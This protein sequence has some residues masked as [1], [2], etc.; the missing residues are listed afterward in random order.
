MKR[1]VAWRAALAV[2]SLA[3]FLAGGASAQAPSAPVD[4][5]RQSATAQTQPFSL[6]QNAVGYTAENLR[7]ALGPA[8]YVAPR[9]EIRG[10]DLTRDQLAAILDPASGVPLAERIARLS[11]AEIVV[12]ELRTE[13]GAAMGRQ[14]ATYR[15]IRLTGVAA[16]RIAGASAAAGSF[17][18]ATPDGPSR[19]TFA[20]TDMADVDLG[21][22]ARLLAPSSTPNPALARLY[23]SASIEGL[24]SEGPKGARTRVA[25]L[26]VR[27]VSARQTPA[28]WL[29]T[30][31]AFA[32]T[33][34][35]NK[36]SPEA[37]T[38][39]VGA[40]A[41]LFEAFEIGAVEATGIEF[42]DASGKDAAGRIGRISY[43]KGSGGS[44]VRL[45][46]LDAGG[47]DGRVRMAAFSMGGI[48]VAPVLSAARELAGK[49]G[50]LTPA[51][52]R[53]LVPLVRSVRSSGIEVDTKGDPKRKEAPMR[54]ALGAV[55]MQAEKPVEN[56]PTDIRFALRNLSV[57]IEAAA[58]DENA[59]Q[60][61]GLGYRQLDASMALD[62]GW[63]EPGQELVIRELSA[64]GA[65]MG[66]ILV[67]GVVGNV[68]RDVFNPDPALSAIAATGAT[69]KSLDVLVTN[70]GLLE[71]LLA[72]EAE[73]K[74]RPVD[75]LR[76]EYGMTAA[77]GIPV[78]LG[79][80]AAAKALGQ[81]VARF[82]AKP[83]RLSLQARTL[84]PAGLGVADFVG[85]TDPLSL[86]DRIELK[87]AA[88]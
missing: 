72:R 28:G 87:A 25:R 12:P 49:P 57:P 53:R 50:D 80:A 16:G 1:E 78:M 11:A 79:N 51:D 35:L 32:G 22:M 59:R 88:E 61:V 20:R 64:E 52:L 75:D 62:L 56:V 31:E 63:N 68:S 84:D 15:D 43:E 6:T 48:S 82:I 3:G 85:A 81:A 19:G 7:F 70:G 74:K 37:R 71:R 46:G 66:S 18:G 41:D 29:A 55:E 4:T 5:S 69:A 42:S 26:S 67:R 65:G 58:K 54:F 39:V 60:L 21:L 77:V 45:E 76:R 17:E 14:V 36:A 34:D 8:T 38:R 83:G 40:L 10:S 23:G 13:T 47:E 27:E 2:A 86:L 30:A 33:T 9:A 44:E 24:T 73:R